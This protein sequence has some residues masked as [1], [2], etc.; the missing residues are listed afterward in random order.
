MSKRERAKGKM[1]NEKQEN[2][3][4]FPIVLLL[5]KQKKDFGMF[6]QTLNEIEKDDEHYEQKL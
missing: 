5:Y 2:I 4:N 1:R 6:Y 3:E